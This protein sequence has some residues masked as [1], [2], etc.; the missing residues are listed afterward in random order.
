[1]YVRR[2]YEGFTGDPKFVR[3]EQA[4]KSFSKLRGA[5]A[6]TYLWRLGWLNGV[7]TPQA[8]Q[9]RDEA[10][11]QRLIREA[12]FAWKQAFAY[13][14]YS[15]EAVFKYAGLLLNLPGRMEDALLITETALEKDPNNEQFEYLRGEILKYRQNEATLGQVQVELDQLVT[16]FQQ[17]PANLTSAFKLASAYA[18]LQQSNAAIAVLDQLI[19]QSNITADAVVQ[20]AMFAQQL[21]NVPLM[22][23]AL[24]RL[25]EVNP[26]SPEAWYDLSAMQAALGKQE[27]AMQNIRRSVLLSD[28]RL[29]TNPSAKNLRQ[30]LANEPRF[31]P[32][33]NRP[34][35]DA[36]LLLQ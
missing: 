21:R 12:E 33:R 6:G 28:R 8:Y 35:W 15:P 13:C 25:T 23:R 10:S 24:L 34:D 5:I 18:Q 3:D 9:P 22:E 29:Q 16:D 4:Q 14:P 19:Q 17:E 20:T 26:N 32:L 7:A 30:E 27:E 11:R 1:V 31:A 2:D 36:S